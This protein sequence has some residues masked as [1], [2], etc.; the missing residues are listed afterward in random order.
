VG[1]YGFSADSG[2]SGAGD[3]A[4][5]RSACRV[6]RPATGNAVARTVRRCVQG[7]AEWP[8]GTPEKKESSCLNIAQAWRCVPTE[9]KM[10]YTRLH[11]KQPRCNPCRA[12]LTGRPACH[13]VRRRQDTVTDVLQLADRKPASWQGHDRTVVPLTTY[14]HSTGTPAGGTGALEQDLEQYMRVFACNP[15]VSRDLRTAKASGQPLYRRPSVVY[16]GR[17]LA[18]EVSTSVHPLGHHAE[19]MMC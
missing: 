8:V 12:Y 1:P 9:P 13:G 18:P 10:M 6:R 2:A 16:K 17:C 15:R 7:V 5:G 19:N 11:G 14:R 3:A 4:C